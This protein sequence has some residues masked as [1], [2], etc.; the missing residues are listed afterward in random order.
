MYQ[1]PRSLTRSLGF[2]SWVCSCIKAQKEEFCHQ[3]VLSD[4]SKIAFDRI[5]PMVSNIFFKKKKDTHK[6]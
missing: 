3:M 2:E 6:E 4:L 5:I 1:R